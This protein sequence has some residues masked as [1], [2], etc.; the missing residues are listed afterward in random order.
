MSY[1]DISTGARSVTTLEKPDTFGGGAAAAVDRQL[2]IEGGR[3]LERLQAMAK[4]GSSPQGGINRIAYSSA[5]VQGRAYVVELMRAAGLET[6]IDAAGN[7]VGRREGLDSTLPALLTG[8]HIDSVP[9]GGI[10]DGTVGVISAIEVAQV[11]AE[12]KLSTRH[13]L[14]VIVFQN[15]EEGL[16]GSR[17]ICGDLAERDLDLPSQSGKTIGEGI[18]YIGG[19]PAKLETAR[20]RPGNIAVYLEYHIEQGPVLENDCIDIGIVEGIVGVNRWEVTIDGFSN[21]AGTTPMD[22][23]K[24]ALL[25]AARFIDAVNRIVRDTPGLQVGTVGRIRVLP[26]APN[27]IP[28]KVILSLDLRDLESSRIEKLYEEIAKA[29]KQIAATV[30]ATITFKQTSVQ[31][32]ALTDARV[33]Q[34]IFDAAVELGLTTKVLRSGAGHDAQAIARIAPMGMIFIPSLAG[35]SHTPEEYSRPTDIVNGANVAL[36]SLLKL[37]ALLDR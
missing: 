37:D 28:G 9:E 6:S 33:R 18:E 24:D 14:E 26:G 13:P 7:I 15:E 12:R 31:V 30:G 36:R 35:I 23:R 20:R 34:S 19:N 25:V 8:S 21:H 17:A 16:F 5:D 29:G 11:L 27:V 22:R 3:I 10:Y 32:P 4:I 2:V 1:S